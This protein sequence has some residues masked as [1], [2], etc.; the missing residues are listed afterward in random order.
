MLNVRIDIEDLHQLEEAGEH[1]YD[2]LLKW[3]Q[4]VPRQAAQAGVDKAKTV[5]HY[6][7]QS[8]NLTSSIKAYTTRVTDR[9]AE[10]VF[11]A[12][13]DP[14]ADY[15]SYVNDGT[16]EHIIEGNP[17]LTF[18]LRSGE[19]ITVRK[20]LHPGTDPDPFFDEGEDEA[21]AKLHELGQTAGRRYSAFLNEKKR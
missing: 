2:K 14:S 12:G 10:A 17:F 19:W 4:D 9:G 13:R 5:K 18:Q 21:A 3:V 15:A 20:V 1:A 6:R 16:Q 8:G 7:D 11:E